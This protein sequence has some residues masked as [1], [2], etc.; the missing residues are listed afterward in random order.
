MRPKGQIFDLKRFRQDH[1]LTQKQVSE[2]VHRPQ[3]FLSAI[4][5]GRRSAPAALLDELV[6]LYKV[7]NIS[8]YLSDPPVEDQD[9]VEDVK[10]SIVNSPGGTVLVN[11]F[12][13]RLTHEEIRKILDI[14]ANAW[15]SKLIENGIDPETFHK[16]PSSDPSPE[17]Q[18]THDTSTVAE[19]VKLLAAS[20]SRNR[21]AD[22]K[23]RELEKRISELESENV[24]LKTEIESLRKPAVRKKK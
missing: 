10:N 17:P 8:D 23:I 7:D 14:E 21:D 1:G 12:A 19:L 18:T 6:H 5:Y 11:E 3:S 4:E 24:S 16:H 22:T 9:A 13:N 15:K 2:A 20:E